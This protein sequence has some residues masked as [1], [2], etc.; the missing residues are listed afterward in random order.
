MKLVLWDGKNEDKVP[1]WYTLEWF[2]KEMAEYFDVIETL[3]TEQNRIAILG[4][5]KQKDEKK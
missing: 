5:L 2:L 3:Q 4:E 1:D